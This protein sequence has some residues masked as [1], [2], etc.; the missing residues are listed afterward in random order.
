MGLTSLLRSVFVVC[1]PFIASWSCIP[2]LH[3]IKWPQ[4]LQKS[5]NHLRLKQ[6]L[7][8]PVWRV[9]YLDS[10]LLLLSSG[11]TRFN[12]F[13]I[14]VS[15]IFYYIILYFIVFHNLH[16]ISITKKKIKI[17][18]DQHELIIDGIFSTL[19]IYNDSKSKAAVESLLKKL[20]EKHSTNNQIL[21]YF[22]SNLKKSTLEALK[23]PD[24]Q[25]R[26][27]LLRWHCILLEN[28][29]KIVSGEADAALALILSSQS[30][31]LSSLVVDVPTRIRNN[32]F[33]R[34]RASLA[35]CSIMVFI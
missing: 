5:H 18:T 35:V 27:A 13:L 31:L 2:S 20:L 12:N 8:L 1:H 21:K 23:T 15:A 34:F 11:W 9:W 28:C 6:K 14:L 25:W 10:L 29:E 32:A 4:N 17:E 3:E 26:I 19:I 16:I 22:L 33:R 7:R 30:S 24:Y